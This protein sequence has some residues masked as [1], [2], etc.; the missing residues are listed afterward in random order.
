MPGPRPRRSLGTRRQRVVAAAV[1]VGALAFLLGRGLTNA[2]EYYLTAKQAIAQRAQLGQED[3]R[4]QGTVLPG[5]RQVGATLHFAIGSG[6]VEVNVVSTGSPPQLF[7][8]G[9]PVVL[10]GHWQG[11]DFASFQIMVQHGSTYVEAHPGKTKSASR[12]P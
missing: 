4:I 1:I 11:A 6:S 9:M 2:M 7:H 5:L 3:F 10:D 8:V 12:T